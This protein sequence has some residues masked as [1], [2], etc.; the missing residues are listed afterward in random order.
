MPIIRQSSFGEQAGLAANAFGQATQDQMGRRL[1]VEQMQRQ[2]AQLEVENARRAALDI[3]NQENQE[4]AFALQEARMAQD[5]AQFMR[6]QAARASRYGLPVNGANVLGMAQKLQQLDP[7]AYAEA[8]AAMDEL[9]AGRYLDGNVTAEAL[10][11]D[12]ALAAVFTD[13]AQRLQV[14]QANANT[15]QVQDTVLQSMEMVHNLD[16]Q[17]AQSNEGQKLLIEMQGLLADEGLTPAEA[18]TEAK[19]LMNEA[20][21]RVGL[22]RDRERYMAQS[23]DLFKQYGGQVDEDVLRRAREAQASMLR[24][25]D[26][27]SSYL[28]IKAMMDPESRLIAEQ[29]NADGQRVGAQSAAALAARAGTNPE[30]AG[31]RDQTVQEVGQ[32]QSMADRMRQRTQRMKDQDAEMGWDSNRTDNIDRIARP[33][34]I[35]DAMRAENLD[36]TNDAQVRAFVEKKRRENPYWPDP[37]PAGAF[38]P[39]GVYNLEAGNSNF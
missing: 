32:S 8:D 36:P 20:T 33:N 38:D 5:D 18:A 11:N 24:V 27:Y 31:L 35:R 14:A 26:P 39:E 28:K 17:W 13:V 21:R 22:K 7:Q 37:P 30:R 3:Q 19:L 15:V 9:T 34:P 12:P 29:A 23:E 1:Q 16:P 6:S 2:R 25:E 4:R 10:D